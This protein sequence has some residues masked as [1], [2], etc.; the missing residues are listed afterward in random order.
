MELNEFILRFSSIGFC[1]IYL[2]VT[3]YFLVVYHN[4]NAKCDS[5]LWISI[6]CNT[7]ITLL[8]MICLYFK[9]FINNIDKYFICSVVLG[10]IS[11]FYSI[12][13]LIEIS[14]NCI[15]IDSFWIYSIINIIICLL[16]GIFLLVQP[17]LCWF[18]A[19]HCLLIG[20][21]IEREV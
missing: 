9:N 6:L 1:I 5:F 21:N 20:V 8:S 2:I 10:I 11:L 15:N 13:P 4:I 18:Y 14:R 16:F 12:F 19:A 3:I 7:I 17:I